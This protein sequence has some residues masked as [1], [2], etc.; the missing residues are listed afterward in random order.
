MS[1]LLLFVIGLLLL[2]SSA[3]YAQD[4]EV[5]EGQE[6]STSSG[7]ERASLQAQKKAPTSNCD[8]PIGI[9]WNEEPRSRQGQMAISVPNSR[10]GQQVPRIE[11]EA[12]SLTLDEEGQVQAKILTVEQSADALSPLPRTPGSTRYNIETDPVSYDAFFAVDLS[13][14]MNFPQK[15][16][17]GT[18]RT[19]RDVA[20]SLIQRITGGG[21]EG[22]KG[23]LGPRDRIFVSGFDDTVQKELMEGL[24]QD[25]SAVRPALASMLEYSP[26][27]ENT[28]VFSAIDENLT[29][30]ERL[31]PSYRS[32]ERRR[33][34]VLF[35]ITDSFNGRD[36]DGRKNL[37]R[38]TQ[39]TPLLQN[40]VEHIGVVQRATDQGLRV[41][42]LALGQEATARGYS[43]TSAPKR[44][45]RPT[46]AQ[47]S[48]TDNYSHRTLTEPSLGVGGSMTSSSE[49]ELFSFIDKEFSG[50]R[51]AYL[52]N[53]E[54]PKRSRAPSR[55][56]VN[57]TLDQ[58]TCSDSVRSSGD[59]VPPMAGG[60]DLEVSPSEMALFLASLL[61]SLLFVPRM[62]TNLLATLGR[63]DEAS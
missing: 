27:S 55:Y 18:E 12:F 37:S 34:A 38:C 25:R 1:R 56:Q 47:K 46:N 62:L 6:G 59:L 39:N 58:R 61:V 19:H 4:A 3:L 31:A 28:A 32:M 48:T 5:E 43:P 15:L 21:P 60:A 36:L 2:S 26:R 29:N 54:L 63:T 23:I 44:S 14:S 53:Y 41:Y 57:V 17:D 7:P 49:E 24:T 10:S 8:H 11:P 33:E 52:L 50:F 45:C 40:L 30:I 35:V 42:I 9:L 16:S 20:V 13:R 22:A 51:Q